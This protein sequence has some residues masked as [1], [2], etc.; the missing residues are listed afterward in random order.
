MLDDLVEN[1]GR[2]ELGREHAARAR[3]LLRQCARCSLR[4]EELAALE[5]TARSIRKMVR[6]LEILVGEETLLREED[7]HEPRALGAGTRGRNREQ[8]PV[9]RDPRELLPRRLEP[10][11]VHHLG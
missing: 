4:L 7:D 5:R 1:R 8:R 9:A 11:V 10:V 3:K 6:E 2:V